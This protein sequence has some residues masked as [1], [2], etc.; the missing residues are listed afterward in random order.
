MP[1]LHQILATFRHTARRDIA[2]RGAEHAARFMT[3]CFDCTDEMKRLYPATVHVD[4]T[5]R[6]QVLEP[7]S[8]APY[9]PLLER[10]H[11]LTGVPILVNTSFNR[12]GEP[13]VASPM[14]AVRTFTWSGIDALAIGRYLVVK[15]DRDTRAQWS[16]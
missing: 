3:V 1:V 14:D 7:G 13:M 10:F 9:R 5:A 15:S 11:A 16:Y 12:R 4:G 6:V 8:I 2:R